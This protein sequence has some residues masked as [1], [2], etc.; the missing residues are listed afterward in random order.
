MSKNSK[1]QILDED[2]SDC[3]HHSKRSQN[4]DTAKI[5]FS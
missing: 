4:I 5:Q 2:K 3:L 1:I